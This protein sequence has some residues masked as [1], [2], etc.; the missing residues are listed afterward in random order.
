[1]LD[2]L[3]KISNIVIAS[4]LLVA[5]FTTFPTY[6]ETV[7]LKRIQQLNENRKELIEERKSLLNEISEFEDSLE[8]KKYL[9]ADSVKKSNDNIKYFKRFIIQSQEELAISAYRIP[10]FA[11]THGDNFNFKLLE[12][13][14]PIEYI[15]SNE[16]TR[17]A[18]LR[19]YRNVAYNMLIKYFDY[20]WHNAKVMKVEQ[21]SKTL[22][23]KYFIV[24][25]LGPKGTDNIKF[26]EKEKEQLYKLYIDY[27]KNFLNEPDQPESDYYQAYKDWLDKFGDLLAQAIIR[28]M[29]TPA[30]D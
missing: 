13:E 16:K 7:S 6:V 29:N 27:Q 2:K 19:K 12:K 20:F 22:Y 14:N 3:F 28:T 24:H 5:L 1:M 30:R 18:I 9:V 17:S 26:T 25:T 8:Y 4:V 23:E 10:K 15:K 11:L 21:A